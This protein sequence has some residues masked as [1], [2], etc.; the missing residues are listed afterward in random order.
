MVIV[1]IAGGSGSRLWPLSTPAYPKHLLKITNDSTLLQNT[2]QR[3]VLLTDDIY[4]IS[5]ASHVKYVYEQL[6]DLS[7]DN[8][9]V[10]PARRGTASCIIAALAKIKQQHPADEPIVFMHA[11]HHIRDTQ[12]FVD[13]ID[14]A[15]RMSVAHQQ[16]VL[17]GVEPT[18]PATGFGYIER[19]KHASQDVPLYTVANFKEKP[20]R[21]VA[22]AYVASGKYL[23]NMGY[24]VAP[25]QV[26]ENNIKAFAPHL[27]KNYQSLIAAKNQA[28]Q[29][30]QYL[31]FK[32]EPIDTAL[33]EQV[34]Q[35]LVTHGAFD[36]MDVGSYPD[37]HL[38]NPQDDEGNTI[39]GT[40]ALEDTSNS[41]IHN[42]TK[43]PLAVIGLD[44]VAIIATPNGI[45]VTNKSHAQKVGDISKRFTG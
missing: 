31:A 1:I 24:F 9:V 35:L 29:E 32:S 3:A 8:I 13:T 15:A 5:E 14:M 44:N 7:R 21:D 19:G 43:L 12:G 25:L 45:L 10:E 11:D 16:I 28:A 27:W 40:I 33:I 23:W 20:K 17:L 42:D 26:F 37:I 4:I 30:K 34:P 18:Y 6:P 39:K 36:W 22:K 41:L 38:I 2:Y